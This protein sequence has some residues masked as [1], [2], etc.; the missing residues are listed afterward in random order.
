MK[1]SL[2]TKLCVGTALIL[3]TSGFVNAQRTFPYKITGSFAGI[4]STSLSPTQGRQLPALL[5]ISRGGNNLRLVS[6]QLINGQNVTTQTVLRANGT[7]DVYTS[8]DGV[9]VQSGTG[10]FS[11]RGR[12]LNANF[13]VDNGNLGPFAVNQRFTLRG[14]R[15][16]FL[17]SSPTLGTTSYLVGNR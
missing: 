4:Q 7:A 12:T 2:V 5:T 13:G 11:R 6:V 1:N 17:E 10:R 14:N 3:L 15:V 16:A 9:I 8:V